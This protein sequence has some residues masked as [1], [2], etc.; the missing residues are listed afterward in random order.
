VLLRPW[1][2]PMLGAALPNVLNLLGF[3][4]VRRGVQVFVRQ[5]PGDR[6]QF[7]V[8]CAGGL[9][10]LVPSWLA[11]AH[12]WVVMASASTMAFILLRAAAEARSGLMSEFGTRAALVSAVPM[13]VVGL[14][15][16]LRALA[17]PFS[18][19]LQGHAIEQGGALN[20]GLLFTFLAMGLLLNFGMGSMVI[21]RLVR[22]LQ[23]LSQHDALTE[24]VN[25]RGFEQRLAAER[26]N[27]QRH[28]RGFALLCIDVDHFKRVN[29]RF[30]HAGGDAV[31]VGLARV[32]QR[33]ARQVDVVART[34]GEEFGL[35][36]PDSDGEGAQ[37]LAQRLLQAARETTHRL[38]DGEVQV[39]LSIGLAV[40]QLRGEPA[41]DLWRRADQALYAAKAAGRDCVQVA[42]AAPAVSG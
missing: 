26:D 29:D 1:L 37:R 7:V 34:G 30:G 41:A 31:L 39:T 15:L 23:H 5:P 3:A 25:R 11:L 32:L 38:G 33:E 16:V 8:L 12:G 6:E 20:L 21:M 10:V 17:V 40:A 2:P 24:L 18:G 27:L 28:G 14:V 9:A 42:A 36:M 22:Q 13:V 35:L 19:N 4:L